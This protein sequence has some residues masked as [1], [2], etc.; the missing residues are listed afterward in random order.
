MKKSVSII[1][2]YYNTP[3]EILTSLQSIPASVKDL[4]Y[5][6]IVIDN[7]SPT[8]LPKKVNKFP[9]VKTIINKE[10]RGYGRA[11]NQ[12]SKLAKGKYLLLMNPDTVFQKDSLA[13]MIEKMEKD[14]SIGILGPQLLDENQK[15]SITGNA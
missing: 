9:H 13:L 4:S 6:V 12:G 3:K 14:A 8:P 10:N 1:Y 2:I 5:E 15:V 7:I 11:L